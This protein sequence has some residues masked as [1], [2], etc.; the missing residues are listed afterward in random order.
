M[1]GQ[2]I[3]HYK[4]LEELGHGGMGGVY[5][6]ED[7]RLKRCVALKFLPVELTQNP[8]ARER[9]ITEAQ[10]ASALDHPNICSIHEIDQ[11][12]N[13]QLFIAMACYTGETL[14]RK[15]DGRHIPPSEVIDI[16][17]QIAQGLSLAHRHGIIHRDISASNIMVT[18][19]GVVK[20]LDFGLATL[21]DQGFARKKEQSSGTLSYMSPEQIAGA[22]I[23]HRTDIWSLGV[24]TYE[25]LTK[26]QPFR[27][28]HT[29]A[30]MYSITTEEPSNL[31]ALCKDVPRELQELCTTCL[32]KEKSARPQSMNELLGMLGH[33]AIR[34]SERQR[35]SR[36]WTAVTAVVLC[37]LVAA[38]FIF[39][40]VH[41]PGDGF[42]RTNIGILK[43][44]NG[45]KDERA[46]TWPETIQALLVTYLTGVE[47]LAIFE[48]V[49]LN[50]MIEAGAPGSAE[51]AKLFSLLA[52]ADV[53]YAL[54]GNM[55]KTAGQFTIYAKMS[56]AATREVMSTWQIAVKT[57]EELPAA[58]D[59]L[60]RQLL[61]Y[62]QESSLLRMKEPYLKPWWPRRFSSMAAVKSF[63]LA[64]QYAF[65]GDHEKSNI[66]MRQAI[67]LDSTFVTPRVWLVVRL[68][69]RRDTLAAAEHYRHLVAAYPGASPFEQAVIRW[70]DAC[71]KG[72]LRD[73]E[74]ALKQALEYSPGNNILLYSLGRVLYQRENYKGVIALLQ[75]A[76]KLNWHYSPM[77]HLLGQSY[78]WINRF[79]EAEVILKE[80]ITMP[81]MYPE[82]YSLLGTIRLRKGDTTGALAYDAQYIKVMKERGNSLPAI[83]DR[84]ATLNFIESRYENGSMYYRLSTAGQNEDPS[85]HLRRAS[86]YLTTA[87]TNLAIGEYFRTLVLDSTNAEAHR[88]LITMFESRGKTARAQYHR[89]ALAKFE[90]INGGK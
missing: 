16:V 39:R 12:E 34:E 33:P 88:M 71:Y 4:I 87:D 46:A 52:N 80:A 45:T 43:F 24:L 69:A 11:V 82:S 56:K 23:D 1:I 57:E 17:R 79:D 29:P 25:M 31:S 75:P 54:E 68:M 27:G 44:S 41:T 77:Y 32:Q 18:D 42:A 64:F 26:R 89:G 50:N 21:A 74:Q 9:F 3:S 22:E 65:K 10:A 7:L 90:S 84:L 53:T 28:D 70:A 81:N 19:D 6:A 76:L 51:G 83:Y 63:N 36:V 72:N 85:E 38:W 73:Q 58:V 13:G 8:E 78:D 20:I 40:N 86:K 47:G 66:Y 60:S 59:S 49:S 35:S 14:R 15:I 48:P 55:L 37:G 30:I 62:L 5:K 67:Q 61:D 2:A